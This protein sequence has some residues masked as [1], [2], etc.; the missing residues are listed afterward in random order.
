MKKIRLTQGKYAI[1]DDENYEWLSKY[2]WIAHKSRNTYYAK[3]YARINGKHSMVSMHRQILGLK[4]GDGKDVDHRNHNGLDN[5]LCNIRICTNSQ[6]QHNSILSKIGT[7]KY[8]G[9]D[10]HKRDK[11][12]RARIWVSGKRINI[13][14]YD[15]EIDAAYAYD[16]KA[17]RHLGEFAT[18]NLSAGGGK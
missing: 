6:N 14:Q 1:V 12:W 16:K 7:S 18:V 11:N 17:K 10:W 4:F 9:V 15:N 3:R 5:R 2:K 8:R 13:G